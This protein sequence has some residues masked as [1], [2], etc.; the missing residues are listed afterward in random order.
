MKSKIFLVLAIVTGLSIPLFSQFKEFYYLT[1]LVTLSLLFFSIKKWRIT[2]IDLLI[3]F[4]ITI[5]LH[6]FRLGSQENFIRLSE[7]A[8]IPLFLSWIYLRTLNKTDKPLTIRKEFLLLLGYLLINIASTKNSLYPVIS[9]K[10]IFILGYVFLLAYMLTD[11]MDKPQKLDAIVKAMV[12]ISGLSSIIAALQCVIPKLII[13]TPVP[14]GS[15][16][17]VTF[18]RAGVG[19]HDPNYYALYLA[20]SAALTLSYILSAQKD[21]LYLKI[22]FILQIIGILATF[23]RTAFISLTLVILYLLN[24]YGKK[25]LALTTSMLVIC[26]AIVIYSSALTI[27]K[28][29]PFLASVVYRVADKNKLVEQPTLVMG[30]RYAAFRAN[31]KMFLDHPFLGVGPFMAMYDFDKYKPA[32]YNYP[33]AWLASHNQYLQLLSEKGA[34]GFILF[35]GFIFVL[36][37]NMNSSLATKPEANFKAYLIGFKSAIFIYLISSFALE[38][39]YELQFWV[40]AGLS[41]AL[42]KLINYNSKN[43]IEQS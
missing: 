28:K 35:L 12:L 6:T 39:S 29:E 25:K 23:S 11:I 9:I 22:C 17:G 20:M 1:L 7:I 21:K 37:K 27:Y 16:F 30:H 38:T 34:F 14:I 41:M 31:W 36:L 5:P 8:F 4:L 13:F 26:S 19:W 2:L 24:Y 10:R 33:T 3:L 40:T 32:G 43:A 42:C 18:Y 15:L